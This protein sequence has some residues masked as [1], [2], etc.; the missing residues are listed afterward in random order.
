M[1]KIPPRVPRKHRSFKVDEERRQDAQYI[2]KPSIPG[3][4]II[5]H[6]FAR[7]HLIPESFGMNYSFPDDMNKEFAFQPQFRFQGFRLTNT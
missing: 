2:A 6:L 7:E 3:E 5:T 1:K 4:V